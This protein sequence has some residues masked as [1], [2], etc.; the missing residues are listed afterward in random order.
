MCWTIPHVLTMRLLLAG[1]F[2]PALLWAGCMGEQIKANQQQLGQQQAQLDQLEQQIEALQSQR[3]S[4]ALAAPQAGSCDDALMREATRKGGERFADGDF[5]HAL[6]YY[7]D[8]VTACPQSSRAHLNVARTDEA[9]GNRPEAIAHYKLAIA[10]KGS[11]PDPS[12]VQ[13]A[14]AALARLH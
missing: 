13:Q 10:A 4:Y 1:F 3:A 11:D 7:Q 9:L 8:A 2:V 12:A 14:Q 6:A 5:T